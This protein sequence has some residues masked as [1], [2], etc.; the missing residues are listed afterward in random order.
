MAKTKKKCINYSNIKKTQKNKDLLKIKKYNSLSNKHLDFTLVKK[1]SKEFSSRTKPSNELPKTSFFKYSYS[2]D[3]TKKDNYGRLFVYQNNKKS[4]L[5]DFE[6]LSKK[7]DFFFIGD[8]QLSNNE[9]YVAYCVDIV[10]DRLFDVYLKQFHEL[11]FQKIISQVCDQIYFSSDSQYLFYIKYDKVDLRPFQLMSYNLCTKK[12]KLI[13]TESDKS[14]TLHLKETS[15]KQFI[16]MTVKSYKEKTDYIVHF[17]SIQK[18]ISTSPHTRVFADHWENC[19]YILKKVYQK[20]DVLSSL[21]LKEFKVLIK[22]KKKV[23]YEKMFIK[24]GFLILI[25]RE[26]SNRKLFIYN[27][28]TKKNYSVQLLHQ[29]YNILFPYLSNLNIYEPI[30]TLKYSTFTQP[31]KLISLNLISKKI[32]TL[33]NFKSESYN[34]S[35]YN[36]EIIQINSFVWLTLLSKKSFSSKLKPCVLY[37]YGSY[38]DTLEP[39]FESYVISLLDRGFLYCI[40]HIR[41]SSINGYKSWLDGKML[42]K[43]NTFTD[44]LTAAKWLIQHKYTQ[45]SKLTIWGRSAGGLLVSNVINQQPQLF[46]LAI[47]GVPFVDVLG[48]MLDSCKPL[49]TEEYEE[50]GNPKHSKVYDYM[51]SYDPLINIDTSL[52]YPN[53]YIYSNINDTLVTYPQVLEYY[54]KIKKS[55]VFTKNNKYALLHLAT[56][57]GHTQGTSKKDKLSSMAEIISI[58]INSQRS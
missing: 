50:W 33:Y 42:Q 34:P 7:N 37:G 47:L 55:K 3:K 26:N 49:T 40:A 20:N 58:I 13:Y 45:P 25:T 48:T 39:V 44:F 21:N 10:G 6:S 1:L 36:E 11:S 56:E 46:N 38:G 27:L 15:D 2:L 17:D 57:F 51:E 43:K 35:L 54:E 9:Q 53:I 31:T 28:F 30:L 24:A 4:T 16:I 29:K 12:T 52:N 14:K 41:G 23:E 18:I 22:N 5:I 32:N 8:Y 19:W